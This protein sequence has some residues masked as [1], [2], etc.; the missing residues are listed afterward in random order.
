M[1]VSC[2]ILE[3]KEAIIEHFDP[4]VIVKAEEIDSTEHRDLKK[5]NWAFNLFFHFMVSHTEI[6]LLMVTN[7]RKHVYES[8]LAF[9]LQV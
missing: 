2:L 9:V 8:H 3:Q 6:I 7:T 5:K 1:F 4:W